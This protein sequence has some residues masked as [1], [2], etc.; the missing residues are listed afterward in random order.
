VSR[1]VSESEA[2]AWSRRLAK[3][4]P[5]NFLVLNMLVPRELRD[6][7]ASVYAFCRWADDL[8][9]EQGPGSEARARSTAL[10]AAWRHELQ[11]C[12]E[13]E[14]D[15]PV[16]VA[17]RATLKKCPLPIA[18]F[19]H[20]IQAFEQ[21]QVVDRYGSWDEL[22]G[23]CRKSANPV[24]RLVLGLFGVLDD[25]SDEVVASSDAICTALQLTN[26]WQ[27]VR[28]DM[29]ERDRVYLP[30]GLTGIEAEELRAWASASETHD[31]VERIASAISPLCERTRAFF[32][33]G[34][35]VIDRTPRRAARLISMFRAGGR[36]VLS[37]VEANPGRVLWRR[38]RLTTMDRAAILCKGVRS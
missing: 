15:H 35:L 23:Y 7:F 38:P 14:A 19:D 1:P 10:L 9:D 20:L 26:F 12:F 32:D 11:R 21:D 24:G 25:A 30:S 8:G 36:R 28:R 37:R 31:R 18:P 27:D 13:G 3:R 34:D 22:V 2:V 6:D 5:E 29:F 16:F 4:H 33:A 17:L